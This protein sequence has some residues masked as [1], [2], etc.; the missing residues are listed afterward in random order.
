MPLDQLVTL[1][2]A[3]PITR[4]GNPVLHRPC[5]PVTEFGPE[6]WA[7]LCNMFATNHAADGPGLAAPQIDV[8][9]GADPFT[10]ESNERV[11]LLNDLQTI[12]QQSGS[13]FT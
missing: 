3:Q 4:W 10:E 6:L 13:I 9:I 7:L 2:T 11:F 8:D 1:G 5:R 12:S